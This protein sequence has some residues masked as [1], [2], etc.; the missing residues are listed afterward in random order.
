LLSIFCACET[1]EQAVKPPD[2]NLPD[3]GYYASWVWPNAGW[4]LVWSNP[5][6]ININPASTASGAVV[7]RTGMYSATGSNAVEAWC[8]PNYYWIRIGTGTDPLKAIFQDASKTKTQGNC[9]F[10]VTIGSTPRQPIPS[11]PVPPLPP[12]TTGY[13]LPT[14]T[15][16]YSFNVGTFAN[17]VQNVL[18][19]GNPAPVGFQLAIRDPKGNLVYSKAFGS[20]TGS[21]PSPTK[22]MTTNRRFDT[23]S[24]SKTIA[25][26]AVMAALEDLA[27]HKPS[28]GVTLDSSILPYLPSTWH[29]KPS[30]ANVTFRAVLR[31]T[32][33]FCFPGTP[34]GDSYASVKSMIE[35]G[36]ESTWVGH[37]HYCDSGF[38]LLRVI[39]PYLV[40][41]PQSYKPFES[42]PTLSAEI[43]AVS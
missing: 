3:I 8:A 2:F 11:V 39:L 33:G 9:F 22:P 40:D 36:P 43:T 35:Y 24:I 12:P 31:H 10:N 5:G 19:A 13:P 6:H 15:T 27:S 16:P 37:W 41:G 26:T 32:A 38:A 23:A 21:T 20:V 4:N 7:K 18:N 29:P 28:L 25:A 17:K 42:N 30:V 34:G 14:S 1:Q